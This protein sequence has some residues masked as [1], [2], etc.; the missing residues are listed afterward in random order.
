MQINQKEMDMYWSV[1]LKNIPK[2]KAI[3]ITQS[4]ILATYVFSGRRWD[5]RQTSVPHQSAEADR[6]RRKGVGHIPSSAVRRARTTWRYRRQRCHEARKE[7]L[8]AYISPH[9]AVKSRIINNDLRLDETMN[10]PVIFTASFGRLL[11]PVGTFSIFRSVSMPSMT[12]PKT[13]CFPSRKS[14]GSVVMKN[15]KPSS[16]RRGDK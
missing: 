4:G 15:C 11:G 9:S 12:L 3:L 6:P 5:K 13:T 7:P 14:H 10:I 16:G 1:H 8:L 2:T